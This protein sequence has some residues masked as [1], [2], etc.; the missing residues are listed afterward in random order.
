[1]LGLAGQAK[2]LAP[3]LFRSGALAPF[4]HLVELDT[5]RRHLKKAGNPVLVD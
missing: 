2:V 3:T 4:A 1:M 5:Q